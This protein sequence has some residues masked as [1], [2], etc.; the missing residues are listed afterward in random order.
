MPGATSIGDAATPL[1]TAP[2]GSAPTPPPQAAITPATATTTEIDVLLM[3]CSVP[4]L[5]RRYFGAL[6]AAISRRQCAF[7]GTSVILRAMRA[8]LLGLA[9][10]CAAV[11]LVACDISVEDRSQP[12]PRRLDPAYSVTPDTRQLHFLAFVYGPCPPPPDRIATAVDYRAGEIAVSIVSPGHGTCLTSDGLAEL[13]VDL[14]EPIGNRRIVS[15][16]EPEPQFDVLGEIYLH[17]R[18]ANRPTPTDRGYISQEQ[19]GAAWPLTVPYGAVSCS[20]AEEYALLV[21]IA[22]DGTLYGLNERG[23]SFDEE[24]LPPIEDISLFGPDGQ[25]VSLSPIFDR[26]LELCA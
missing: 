22:P 8:R 6:P 2:P 20:G 17:D 21:F 9:I 18:G 3:P 4:S 11:V 13:A 1:G 19:L 12:L 14:S 25:H 23:Q 24:R 16:D 26:G 15:R 10:A 5:R 7:S